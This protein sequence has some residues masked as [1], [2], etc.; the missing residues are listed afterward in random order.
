MCAPCKPIINCGAAQ[1]AERAEMIAETLQSIIDQPHTGRGAKSTRDE[2]EAADALYQQALA[3]V[4]YIE[5][6]RR[7][8][9]E[10]ARIAG[11]SERWIELMGRL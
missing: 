5:A 11:A 6:T 3:D 4:E 7:S 8:G 9:E 10:M 2:G 1:A